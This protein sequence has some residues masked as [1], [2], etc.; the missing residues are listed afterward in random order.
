MLDEALVHIDTAIQVNGEKPIFLFYRSAVLLALGKS[1]E[2]ILQLE[3]AMQD[4][5]KLLKKFIE[6]NPAILQNQYVVDVS[7]RFKKNKR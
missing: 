5:P 3:V 6:L 2:A 1:K 4:T 7:A